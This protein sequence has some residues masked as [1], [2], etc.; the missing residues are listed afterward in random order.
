MN[1][2]H[3]H[4]SSLWFAAFMSMG[5]MCF[6]LSQQCR[7]LWYVG[8][9]LLVVGIVTEIIRHRADTTVPKKRKPR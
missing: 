4:R 8:A 2:V 3:R 5:T 6:Y 7:P 9:G 1:P